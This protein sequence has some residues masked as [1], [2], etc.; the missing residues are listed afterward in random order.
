MIYKSLV[1]DLAACLQIEKNKYANETIFKPF[2]QQWMRLASQSSSGAADDTEDISDDE[3]ESAGGTESAC[4]ECFEEVS[5]C[6]TCRKVEFHEEPPSVSSLLDDLS[7]KLK[8]KTDWD[9]VSADGD[10]SVMELP[11]YVKE[12]VDSCLSPV[13]K[14][15]EIIAETRN[16]SE[17]LSR[18]WN[19]RKDIAGKIWWVLENDLF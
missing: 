19:R 8:I 12:F 11:E 2:Y 13:G 1:Q 17:N 16:S 7:K 9:V 4:D 5:V 18:F 15:Q 6:S 10:G 3:A 14:K